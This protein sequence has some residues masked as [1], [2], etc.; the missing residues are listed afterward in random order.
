MGTD[1][2]T[3]VT[4][5]TDAPTTLYVATATNLPTKITTTFK[6]SIT[7]YPTKTKTSNVDNN[8]TPTTNAPT[9][10][11]TI[12]THGIPTTTLKPTITWYPT[13]AKTIEVDDNLSYNNNNNNTSIQPT[14]SLT[15]NLSNNNI[16]SNSLVES[17]IPTA[18]NLETNDNDDHTN[19]VTSTFLPTIINKN[20]TYNN[21]NNNEEKDNDEQRER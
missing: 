20:E 1:S 8:L 14:K 10:L 19:S 12:P 3:I 5:A 7:W 13:I 4:P 9:I 11:T 15:S 6:P 17:L 16:P 21:N 18:T 2:I